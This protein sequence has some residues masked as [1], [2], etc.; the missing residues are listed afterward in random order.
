MSGRFGEGG[1]PVGIAAFVI[2]L[3]FSAISFIDCIISCVNVK[4]VIDKLIKYGN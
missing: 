3:I 1:I 4:V 2:S